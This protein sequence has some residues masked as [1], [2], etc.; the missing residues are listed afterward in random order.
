MNAKKNSCAGYVSDFLLSV[1]SAPMGVNPGAL[2][3]KSFHY[4]R[5]YN[6]NTVF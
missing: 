2:T 4:F 6:L 3:K 1:C 5:I